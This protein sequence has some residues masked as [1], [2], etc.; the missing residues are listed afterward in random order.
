MNPYFNGLNALVGENFVRMVHYVF[1]GHFD[2]KLQSN[3]GA[4][5]TRYLFA[6][7]NGPEFGSGPFAPE[8][9]QGKRHD[10]AFIAAANAKMSLMA[11]TYPMDKANIGYIK[12]MQAGGILPPR[13]GDLAAL[14]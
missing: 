13:C 10:P 11:T 5:Y 4:D 12:L 7:S 14:A 2:P 6:Y 1:T 3:L 9:V 8:R